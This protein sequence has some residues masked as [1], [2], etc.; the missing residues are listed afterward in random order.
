[1]SPRSNVREDEYGGTWQNRVRFVAEMLAAIRAACGRSFIVGLKL[2]GDDGT[3]GSIGPA[4]AA[5]VAKLLTASGEASY[6]CFAQ[7]THSLTLEMHVPDRFGPRMPYR[8]LIRGLRGAIPGVPLIALGRITD[9]AEAEGLLAA[10]EAELIGLGRALVADPAWPIKAAQGRT[11]EIRYC[12]SCNTCWDT[13]VTRHAP[14]ACVQNP[15]VALPDE[16]DWWPARQA[17]ARR[18]AVVGA[19]I[20]GLE[21]AWVAAARGHAVTV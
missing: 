15:R 18:V 6:A 5:I 16:V 12:I 2:P 21:A 4:E 20:A 13:I 3:E 7:G 17:K 14:M 8:E 9:P 10:G 11:N 19:G 1:L